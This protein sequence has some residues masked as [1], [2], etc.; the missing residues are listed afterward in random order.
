M[1]TNTTNS[2][3]NEDSATAHRKS[4]KSRHEHMARDPKF[5][6]LAESLNDLGE[7]EDE[8]G[9]AALV[10]ARADALYDDYI[11]KLGQE[12]F[13]RQLHRARKRL[14]ALK[15]KFRAADKLFEVESDEYLGNGTK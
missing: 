12:E 7:L 9:E 1:S 13:E 3:A 14:E 4:L 11:K 15:L 10:V 8:L 2:P 5:L 6:S